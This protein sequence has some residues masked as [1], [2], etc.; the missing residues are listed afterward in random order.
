MPV[1]G[2][3]ARGGSLV[4]GQ[5]RKL[6]RECF[7]RILSNNEKVLRSWLMYSPFKKALYCFC[8]RLF[9]DKIISQFECKDGFNTWWKLNPKFYQNMNLVPHMFDFS[10]NGRN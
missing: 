3:V 7:F 4:K 8:C 2:E 5:N 10:P 9:A 1:I 6:T